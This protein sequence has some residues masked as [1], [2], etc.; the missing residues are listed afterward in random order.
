M[1]RRLGGIDP[2][3]EQS[4]FKPLDGGQPTAVLVTRTNGLRSDAPTPWQ[5]LGGKAWAIGRLT[6]MRGGHEGWDGNVPASRAWKGESCPPAAVIMAD[7][8]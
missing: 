7:S 3:E 5:P 4:E 1:G 8:P 6:A 2:R